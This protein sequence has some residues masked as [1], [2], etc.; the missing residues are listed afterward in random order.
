MSGVP[1][2]FGERDL[3][4]TAAVFSPTRRPAPLVLGHPTED[5]PAY[6][7]VR[8]LFVKEGGLFAQAVVDTALQT[9]VKAGRYRYVSASFISPFASGNP[10]PGA[11]Y[12]K[13][14]G[15]LGATP[16]A[17]RGM[18]PPAFARQTA[19][20]CFC[21]GH[22]CSSSFGASVEFAEE[23]GLRPGRRVLHAL[24]LDYQRVCPALSYMEAISH[25]QPVIF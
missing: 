13:H 19:S 15:F 6:G 7:Q 4:M 2:D 12:L 9:L 21:E 20:F 10:A 11:Y 17:V 24:A 5:K 14:V 3:Q 1:L 25:A 16:P 22:D 8:S 18:A 23:D